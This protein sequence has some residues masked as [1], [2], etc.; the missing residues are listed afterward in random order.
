[1]PGVDFNVLRD[2]ITMEE[3]LNQLR[4]VPATRSGYQWHGGCPVIDAMG[5]FAARSGLLGLH[6]KQ[7]K[8]RRARIA[9]RLSHQR[10]SAAAR[11]RS[12]RGGA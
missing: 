3:V 6:G 4:F 12:L 11:R 7:G 10:L 8:N 2:E 1:M 9:S 5:I